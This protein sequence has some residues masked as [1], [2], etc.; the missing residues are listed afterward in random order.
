MGN[1]IWQVPSDNS[2]AQEILNWYRWNLVINSINAFTMV[3]LLVRTYRNSKFPYVYTT[4]GMMF[5]AAFFSV[6]STILAD[7]NFGC[8]GFYYLN[9]KCN[10][11]PSESWIANI[12]IFN[13]LCLGL[14]N[15][16]WNDGH[17]IFAFRYFEVAEMFGR[18]DKSLA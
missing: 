5:L 2:G 4:G 11:K 13:D 7:W 14:S 8:S 16:F 10:G 15:M 6:I 1:I 12:D 9:E 18:K 17:F 3:I